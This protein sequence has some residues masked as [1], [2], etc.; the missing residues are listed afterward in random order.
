MNR[1]LE[2]DVGS[3][4]TVVAAISAY[5]AILNNTKVLYMAPTE[6]LA[7]QH[8]ETFKNLFQESGVEINLVTGRQR[9]EV[10]KQKGESVFCS[11]SSE[12][13]PQIYI[14]THALLYQEDFTNIGLVIIDEQHRF[15]VEQRA[16]LLE[17]CGLGGVPHLL[18]MTATPIPRSLQLILLGDLDLSVIDEMPL[19]RK[20]VKT[21]VV[22]KNKRDDAYNWVK[23]QKTPA[24]VVCPFIEE[25][26][27]ETLA[28]VR[29]ATK[30]FKTLQKLFS[31]LRVGLLHGRLKATEKTTTVDNFRQG[32]LDILVTT[33][34]VEVGV[35][36]P[37]AS[38]MIV[39][40]AERF[41]LASLHQLRGR[42]GRA[43]QQAYCLLFTSDDKGETTR[44][45]F[46][47]TVY[48]GAE[49][50]QIDL[51]FRGG[52]DVFGTLQHGLPRFKIADPGNTELVGKAKKWAE[53]VITYQSK[54]PEL[55]TKVKE[56]TSELVAPN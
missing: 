28:A 51:K 40:G 24:F 25:S 16:H 19:G 3:G 48:N 6:I 49:L 52:G 5:A 4:K 55:A 46:L 8:F 11:L 9:T 14:G 29:A 38:I 54:Y 45:K 39:E 21:W 15:G 47:E 7:R 2:G 33:P 30:E 44:L 10:R 37:Q 41:G 18:T 22:P 20:K 43:G 13:R 32:R 34:V 53:E 56:I 27:T 36:I 50:A 31:P 26:E 42:V 23:N 12:I 17:K 1:L 35:D